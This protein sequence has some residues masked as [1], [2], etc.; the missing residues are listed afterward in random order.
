MEVDYNSAI[1][2]QNSQRS[3]LK[4]PYFFVD[5]AKQMISS[6]TTVQEVSFK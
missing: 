3:N 2:A 6:E 5:T 4:N 1:N